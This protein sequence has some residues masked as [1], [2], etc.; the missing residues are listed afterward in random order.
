MPIFPDSTSGCVFIQVS[1]ALTSRG[2]IAN[3]SVPVPPERP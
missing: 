1:A 3:W 2:N